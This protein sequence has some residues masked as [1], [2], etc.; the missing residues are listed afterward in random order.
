[1]NLTHAWFSVST[2]NN[3][4]ETHKFALNSRLT[5]ETIIVFPIFLFTN[6]LFLASFAITML[7]PKFRNSCF[8]KSRRFLH[9]LAHWIDSACKLQLLAA[10][11]TLFWSIRYYRKFP[12][13]FL[14]L[15]ETNYL[16][17]YHLH[18]KFLHNLMLNSIHTIVCSSYK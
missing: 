8:E 13:W 4:N 12:M 16:I 6:N 2:Q 7:F 11:R 9:V 1:M 17:M 15:L 3:N 18:N 5:G 10:Y 14:L